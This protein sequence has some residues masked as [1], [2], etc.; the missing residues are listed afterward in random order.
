MPS[1]QATILLQFFKLAFPQKIITKESIKKKTKK[2][3]FYK[4]F[5]SPSLTKKKQTFI[6]GVNV[7]IIT[8]QEKTDTIIIYIH[9]GGYV[10]KSTYGHYD[11]M[12]RL[13]TQTLATIYAVNYKLAP[14][15]QFPTQINEVKKVYLDLLKNGH[16]PKNIFFVGD[17]AG[18]NLAIETAVA[19]RNEKEK[20][21]AGIIAIS[22]PTDFTLTYP[23]FQTNEKSDIL[24]SQQKM[25]FFRDCYLGKTSE[26]NP[27]ASPIFADLKRLPKIQ[28][29]VSDNELLIDD[30]KNFAKKLAKEKV[31]HE[32]HIGKGLAHGY[33]LAARFV[34]EAK[35]SI[36]LMTKF[37]K[38]N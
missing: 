29:F 31:P 8:P 14:E 1:I 19:L 23:S 34:P 22:P 24:L 30:V 16:N 12:N 26:K 17:S 36:K 2:N 37:I 38:E 5:L 18:G 7:E 21:P 25:Y 4:I 32:L 28:L 6:E 27:L 35:E 10:Y 20:L 9:G 15:Y 13:S 11:L 33:P 3:T